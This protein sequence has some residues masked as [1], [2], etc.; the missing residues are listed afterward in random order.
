MTERFDSGFLRDEAGRLA[1]STGS[2]T[3]GW[4]SGFVRDSEGRLVVSGPEGAPLGGASS[5]TLTVAASN[6]STRAKENAD[7][8]CD[9]TSDQ[10]QINEALAAL[11]AVAGG[12][13]L[14]SE[15]AFSIE[16]SI[17]VFQDGTTIDGL[18]SG[19]STGGA[20][21]SYATNPVTSGTRITLSKTFAAGKYAVDC[22]PT[23][24]IST[25]TTGALAGGEAT[26]PVSSTTGLPTSG[27]VRVQSSVTG[28]GASVT[29][30]GKTS[31]TLTGCAGTP[32]ALSGALVSYG[33][34]TLA[35]LTLRDFSIDGYG[36]GSPYVDANGI[37]FQAFAS[38]VSNVKINRLK[39]DGFVEDGGGITTFPHG[40]WD[41]RITNL[42]VRTVGRDCY[43]RVGAATDTVCLG[44]ILAAST[45]Y[46][47]YTDDGPG[48]QVVGGHFY[49][50]GDN[51]INSSA[52]QLKV[53]G[54]RFTDCEKGGIYVTRTTATQGGGVNITGNGF[55]DVSGAAADTYDAIN[56][57]P[58]AAAR[59]GVIDAN[60]F[61]STADSTR[62]RYGVNIANANA[63]GFTIGPFSS[64][65]SGT[66]TKAFGTAAVQDLG[67]GTVDVSRPS[68]MAILTTGQ[69]LL[70]QN[71]DRQ[72]AN[73][74]SLMIGGTAYA[75]LIPLKEG[76]KI[77]NLYVNSAGAGSGVTLFKASIL[78]AGANTEYARTADQSALFS[79]GGVK[80]LPLV[81]AWV[82]PA[83]GV[84]LV[85][86]VATATTTLPTLW[87][88]TVLASVT[89]IGSSAPAIA[90]L[91]TG[92]TDLPAAPATVGLTNPIAYWVG[93]GT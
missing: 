71:F 26:I 59:G 35:G 34:R 72:V 33:E 2:G 9:G 46:G 15:G 45:R 17:V 91:G 40:A 55:R 58:E 14:L 78:S 12:K 41:N 22:R 20:A 74:S 84:Y 89:K 44:P 48:L 32:A 69:G 86:I 43:R 4:I 90:T 36:D 92:L 37:Y 83:T 24:N 79:S 1:L 54:S 13:V 61:V 29:Y 87:R 49:L 66:A 85:C 5:T 65:Y 42:Q 30:T 18:G 82:V 62:M 38:G 63:V 8:V 64:G 6:A 47:I 68:A 73:T 10:V 31:T 50:H 77:G 60:E 16:D 53:M 51:A 21:A 7:F 57:A 70:S 3:E 81:S 93:A 28:T 23:G 67:T 52:R 39:G 80:T 27:T 75:M 11:P 19:Y 76:D 56:I 88:G 25:Q